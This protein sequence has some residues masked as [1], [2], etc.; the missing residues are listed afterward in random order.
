ML[1]GEGVRA[2]IL[3]FNL[4]CERATRNIVG[5]IDG[6]SHE[7]GVEYRA[8]WCQLHLRLV[9]STTILE[10]IDQVIGFTHDDILLRVRLLDGSSGLPNGR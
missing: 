7:L 2:I 6:I 9:E 3:H 8:V 5:G 1:C 10:S 4:W